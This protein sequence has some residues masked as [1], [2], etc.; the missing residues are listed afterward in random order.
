LLAARA[1][2]DDSSIKA[3]QEASERIAQLAGNR[4]D[5]QWRLA[6]LIWRMVNIAR[7]HNRSDVVGTLEAACDRWTAVVDEPAF[8][9]WLAEAMTAE[10]PIFRTAGVRL[11]SSAQLMQQFRKVGRREN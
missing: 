5:V 8:A 2:L 6:N 9:R 7:R 4:P 3:F 1:K 10:A 11:V